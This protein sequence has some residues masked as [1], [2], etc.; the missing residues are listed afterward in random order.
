MLTAT[1]Q[2]RDSSVATA[3]VVAVLIVISVVVPYAVLTG[4][5]ALLLIGVRILR[6][7]TT[8]AAR[9]LGWVAL[10]SGLLLLALL[11]IFVVGFMATGTGVLSESG[12]VRQARP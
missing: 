7:Q 11:A 5:P 1:T 2:P 10:V 6:R 9:T 4:A 8:P 12:P 3:I